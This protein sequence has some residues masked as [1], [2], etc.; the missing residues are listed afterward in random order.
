MSTRLVHAAR[1]HRTPGAP[2]NHPIEVASTYHAGGESDYARDGTLGT[3]ALEEAVGELEGGFA[4]AFSSGMAAAC[5]ILDLLGNDAVVVTGI[6][7]Y[8]GVAG[9]MRQLCDAGRIRLRR[10]DLTDTPVA[11]EAVDGAQ[12]A[13]IETPSNPMLGVSDI[14]A[15]SQ[16]AHAGKTLVVCDSTFATPLGQR[17]LDL[18]AD[19]VLHSGTKSLGGHSDALL[20]LAVTRDESLA[21]LLRER[22]TLLGGIPGALECYLI[23]RGM[24]TLHL[25]H[26]RAQD[27]ARILAER[28]SQHPRVRRVHYPGL[29]TDPGSALA[30]RQ[31]NGPGSLIAIE[32]DGDA[33]ETEAVCLRTQLWAHATSLGGVESLLE[34]RRR[35]EFESPEVPENLIRLSVGI[36]DV[37]DLWADLDAALRG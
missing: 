18:G 17:T 11:L 14:A 12:M 16:A 36:E 24:R 13:W 32:Y 37:E 25:R 20:G 4:V 31:M 3:A 5:A 7:T 29:P 10:V 33:E 34:R 8:A 6:F 1:P 27:S 28:L 15:I 21:A 19:I 22:R 35:W 9:R 2:L 26:S 30:S 23:L